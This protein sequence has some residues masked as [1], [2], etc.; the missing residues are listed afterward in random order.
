MQEA[1]SPHAFSRTRT[2]TG[3]NGVKTNGWT[4][5]IRQDGIYVNIVLN[6]L[7]GIFVT[8]FECDAET[9]IA[10]RHAD[11]WVSRELEEN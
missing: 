2:R 11:S 3:Y 5:L 7:A 8:P 6:N 4:V 1:R 10:E 9:P